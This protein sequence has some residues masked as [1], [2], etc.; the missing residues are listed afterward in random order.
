MTKF[1]KNTINF[2]NEITLNQ[3]HIPSLLLKH[4]A[5]LGLNDK[6]CLRLMALINAIPQGKT[7]LSVSDLQNFLG[8]P[9]AEAEAIIAGFAKRGF[10]SRVSGGQVEN[11]YSLKKFYDE[12]LE[13]WVFLQACPERQNIAAETAQTAARQ[14]MTP[15]DIKQIYKMFEAEKGEPLSPTEMEKLNH[16]IIDDNWSAEMM[17]EALQRAV[18]HGTSHFA[19]I[20]KILL[21]WQKAGITQL[22]QLAA[23]DTEPKPPKKK[24]AKKASKEKIMTNE[25]DYNDVY[26]IYKL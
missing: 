19:Y 1:T 15:D 23:E 25:T 17:K 5:E 13:L 11:R 4:Y 21:R 18:L 22:S 7:D 12:M 8:C 9:V 16:W 26:K 6:D 14:N 24:T 2:I 3:C 10:I 20:D